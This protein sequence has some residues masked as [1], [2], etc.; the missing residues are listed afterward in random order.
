[1]ELSKTFT[2][3][4]PKQKDII[5]E[6]VK[7]DIDELQWTEDPYTKRAYHLDKDGYHFEL[8]FYF[9]NGFIN[10]NADHRM[11]GGYNDTWNQDG[12][13]IF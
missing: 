4:T 2:S 13:K 5:E 6:I 7:T 12:E 8:I 10:V 11:G 3:Y 1:M 9:N